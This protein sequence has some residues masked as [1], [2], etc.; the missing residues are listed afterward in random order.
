MMRDPSQ[1]TLDSYDRARTPRTGQNRQHTP[2]P[3]PKQDPDAWVQRIALPALELKEPGNPKSLE[4]IEKLAVGQRVPRLTSPRSIKA[5]LEL[6]VDPKMLAPVTLADFRRDKVDEQ[7]WMLQYQHAVDLR[8]TLMGK[9]MDMRSK[10]EADA[11][12]KQ[13]RPGKAAGGGGSTA[14]VL[15]AA[16][17][18]TVQKA[19]E[20]LEQ[21]QEKQ[22]KLAA[23]K[24]EAMGDNARLQ[25]ELQGKIARV[26]DMAERRNETRRVQER[27][28]IEDVYQGTMQAAA[29]ERQAE[30]DQRR[31]V[32]MQ[33]KK[34]QGQLAAQRRAE[35]LGKVE[36]AEAAERRAE[37]E[38]E[39]TRRHQAIVHEQEAAVELKRNQMDTEERRRVKLRRQREVERDEQI[40]TTA[41]EF[42]ARLDKARAAAESNSKGRRSE[43]A[44]R[45]EHAAARRRAMEVERGQELEL[46]IARTRE[47]AEVR[48]R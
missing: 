26:D 7:I 3:K 39:W 1:H 48:Q 31:D 42:Q 29:A 40:A 28:R 34:E 47:K 8:D 25:K 12:A 22:R 44:E 9:L 16:E 45:E 11:V 15:A 37:R 35:A 24:V 41:A 6:G 19:G 13:F 20:R 4:Q 23:S 2:K 46:E 21:R 27:S 17:S 14:E 5:C 18:S 32:A 43:Q 30:K 10:S 38:R 33:L 36:A